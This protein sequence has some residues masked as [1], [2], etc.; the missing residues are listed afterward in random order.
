MVTTYDAPSNTI[1][2]SDDPVTFTDI[3][4]DVGAPGV[5]EMLGSHQFLSG[6]FLVIA[7]GGHVTDVGKSL[8]FSNGI[9]T[10]SYARIIEVESGGKI[11]LGNLLDAGRKS[12]DQ[13][14]VIGLLETTQTA[15]CIWGLSGSEMYFYSTIFLGF[16]STL[17][18]YLYN[19]YKGN[20]WNCMFD[21]LALKPFGDISGDVNVHNCNFFNVTIALFGPKNTTID[22]VNTYDCANL[23]W[24]STTQVVVA[25]NVYSIGLTR[26]LRTGANFDPPG[27]VSFIDCDPD[28]WAILWNAGSTAPAYRKNTVNIQ[29][30][31]KDNNGIEDLGVTLYD[32]DG[33]TTGGFSEQTTDANGQIT[34]Q[35][36]IRGYCVYGQNNLDTNLTKEYSPHKLEL[37]KGGWE[38]DGGE[39]TLDEIINWR[40]HLNQSQPIRLLDGEPILA[41]RPESAKHDRIIHTRIS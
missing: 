6:A 11:T 26:L 36:A 8:Y 15:P 7:N 30:L 34:E 4:T 41:L 27:S 17:M 1:T 12:S 37:K 21:R 35:I 2:V 33:N 5:W 18:G 24:T 39:F 19:I 23:M 31:D 20:I 28:S 40:V 38:A 9:A 16:R 14:C 10:G 32:V 29:S 22:K 13:G 3:N 25:T